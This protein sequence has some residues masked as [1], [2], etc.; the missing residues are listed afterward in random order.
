MRRITWLLSW[1]L[2]MDISKKPMTPSSV[3]SLQVLDKDGDAGC[4]IDGL[5]FD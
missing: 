4:W 2:I 3:T 1:L 5:Y